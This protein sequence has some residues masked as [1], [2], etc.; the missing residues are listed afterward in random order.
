MSRGHGCSPFAA[1]PTTFSRK[2]PMQ[3]T[4]QAPERLGPPTGQGEGLSRPFFHQRETHIRL[5]PPFCFFAPTTSKPTPDRIATLVVTQSATAPHHCAAHRVPQA[6]HLQ[7]PPPF[8]PAKPVAVPPSRGPRA[9]E[10]TVSANNNSPRQLP[11]S[12]PPRHQAPRL[13]CP[14]LPGTSPRC[15]AM[16][17]CFQQS[18]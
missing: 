2:E 8:K 6:V 11:T 10:S 17:R 1:T 4:R 15:E 9:T 16:Q 18:R 7:R 14:G 13:R 3:P 5:P 12:Y